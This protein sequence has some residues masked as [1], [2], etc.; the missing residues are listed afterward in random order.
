MNDSKRKTKR[1][2]E[3]KKCLV[4]WRVASDTFRAYVLLLFFYG[5]G[6]AEKSLKNLILYCCRNNEDIFP[7]NNKN[8]IPLFEAQQL[9]I[10]TSINR[11]HSYALHLYI[12]DDGQGSVHVIGFVVVFDLIS[13]ISCV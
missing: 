6:E 11:S 1:K 5:C 3:E 7:L 4:V 2:E 9:N 10:E 8:M 12:S 13:S